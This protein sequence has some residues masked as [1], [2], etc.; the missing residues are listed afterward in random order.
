MLGINREKFWQ[1][2]DS[3]SEP[4]ASEPCCAKTTAVIYFWIKR[5]GNFGQMKNNDPTEWFIFLVYYIYGE[6]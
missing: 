6:K 1:G 2:S 3:N 5:F 4:T